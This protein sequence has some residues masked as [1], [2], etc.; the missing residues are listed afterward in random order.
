MNNI[1]VIG[2]FNDYQS[3]QGVMQKE[4]GGWFIDIYLPPGEHF[5]KFLI[6]GEVPLTD[7]LANIYATDDTGEVWSVIVIDDEGQ[8]LYD[9]NQYEVTV[10]DYVLSGRIIEVDE[11]NPIGKKQFNLNLD[12]KAV[13]RFGFTNVIGTHEV[14]VLWYKPNGT[15]YSYSYNG[16]NQ[17]EEESPIFLWFWIPLDEIK[18]ESL[19]GVWTIKLFIDGTYVLEDQMTINRGVFYQ[20]YGSYYGIKV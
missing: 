9:N 8:R 6:N 12:K 18:E 7:P 13:A 3:E 2:S 10:E 17:Q 15:L 20:G 1:G 11:P 4:A 5:Y 19:E 14:T 16:L